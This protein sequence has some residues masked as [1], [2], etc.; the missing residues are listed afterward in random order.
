MKTTGLTRY[1]S[2]LFGTCTLMACGSPPLGPAPI[3]EK[4]V[5]RCDRLTQDF[6]AKVSSGKHVP[7]TVGWSQGGATEEISEEQLA[8]RIVVGKPGTETW[9]LGR[10][11]SGKSRL[12]ESVHAKICGRALVIRLDCEMDL[13]PK[14]AVAT[15]KQ[16][17]LA[18]ALLEQFGV[19]PGEDMVATLRQQLSGTWTL[20]VDGGDELTPREQLMLSRDLFWLAKAEVPPPHLVRFERPGFDTGKDGPKPVATA[21]VHELSAAQADAVLARRFKDPKDLEAARKWLAMTGLDNTRTDA[22]GTRYVHLSTWR[23][24]EM[25]ADLAEDAAKGMEPFGVNGT[26]ADLWAAWVGHRLMPAAANIE[27][28]IGWM[29]RIVQA[30]A[31]ESNEPDLQITI[32]RCVGAARPA[33]GTAEAACGALVN[34][35]LVHPSRAPATWALRNRTLID[36]VLSRW[37]VAKYADCDMLSAAVSNYASLELTAMV[38]SQTVGRRCLGNLVAA[39]CSRG[40]AAQELLSFVDEAVPREAEFGDRVQKALETAGSACEREV[41]TSLI[42]KNR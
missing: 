22:L 18:M 16:P 23:D 28:G 7:I 41:L 40:I 39:V 4:L 2:M 30:G 21:R 17:A 29:D 1:L 19:A 14:M 25:L 32:E 38:A 9:V 3:P 33:V 5:Y 36:L 6:A 10:G 42:P 11:G 34:S 37:L 31:A 26:R 20:I 24:A 8:E 13:V 12:A 35:T 27:S 15:A